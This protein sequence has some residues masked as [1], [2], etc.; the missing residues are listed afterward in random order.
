[1]AQ[2]YEIPMTEIAEVIGNIVTPENIGAISKEEYVDIRE[3]TA[4]ALL[5]T[6]MHE[7]A[8]KELKV[9][10]IKTT[11]TNTKEYPFND[12]KQTLALKEARNNLNYIV[13]VK[14]IQTG[15]GGIGEIR[16]T[17]KQ[18]NGFKIE[19]TG[20]AKSVDVQCAVQGGYM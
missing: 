5:Y 12:S 18:L 14:A 15:Q 10:T 2:N 20:A 6:K 13:N 3:S 19:F 4:I 16:I 8:L 11:L 1:M 17:D 9:E 7:S